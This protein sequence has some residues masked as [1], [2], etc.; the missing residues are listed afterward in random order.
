VARD[1]A[2]TVLSNRVVSDPSERGTSRA[3]RFQPPWGEG[4]GMTRD[5]AAIGY[6]DLRLAR[7]AAPQFP[8]WPLAVIV[9]SVVA[10]DRAFLESPL[11]PHRDEIL[12][13]QARFR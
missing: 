12:L 2:R 6:R 1:R 9:A 4:A 7:L 13:R 11:D 3:I 8:G 5:G 10:G